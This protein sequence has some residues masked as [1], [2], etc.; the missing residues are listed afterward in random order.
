MPRDFIGERIDFIKFHFLE[1]PQYQCGGEE[2][3]RA[4]GVHNVNP[5]GGTIGPLFRFEQ[6]AIKAMTCLGLLD[7][8]VVSDFFSQPAFKKM[9]ATSNKI[10]GTRFFIYLFARCSRSFI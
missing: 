8:S 9:P 2:I 1:Q 3:A 10:D 6:Q 7:T 4:D 5:H